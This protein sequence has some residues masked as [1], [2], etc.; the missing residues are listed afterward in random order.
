V[1][2][3]DYVSQ[4]IGPML[5]KNN[6]KTDQSQPQSSRMRVNTQPRDSSLRRRSLYGILMGSSRAAGQ[7]LASE[8]EHGSHISRSNRAPRGKYSQMKLTHQ[9][10]R[11]GLGNTLKCLLLGCVWGAALAAIVIHVL[12]PPFHGIQEH[13]TASMQGTDTDEGI[14]SLPINGYV[15]SS[16][17]GWTPLGNNWGLLGQKAFP[18]HF[19]GWSKDR[20]RMVINTVDVGPFTTDGEALPSSDI[21]LVILS[22]GTKVSQGALCT[23]AAMRFLDLNPSKSIYH[24]IPVG[25]SKLKGCHQEAK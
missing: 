6:T 18:E 23:I 9:C 1:T 10:F 5:P 7:T 19:E 12:G 17:P 16:L 13:S 22:A 15:E 4:T 3:V 14:A 25:Y 2:L 20:Q 21:L 24:S 8:P 11:L